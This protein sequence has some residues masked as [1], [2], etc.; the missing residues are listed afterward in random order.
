MDVVRYNCTVGSHFY[1]LDGA[2]KHPAMLVRLFL[3]FGAY[4][5][6]ILPTELSFYKERQY[7]NPFQLSQTVPVLRL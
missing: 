4:H 7:S 1:T 3:Q 5:H 2:E 6:L